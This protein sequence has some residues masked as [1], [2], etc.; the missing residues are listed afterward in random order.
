M[1]NLTV[2]GVD[3][4][5][6]DSDTELRKVAEPDLMTINKAIPHVDD[7]KVVVQAGGACG[8]WPYFLSALFCEVYTFEPCPHNFDYLKQNIRGIK[9]I[10]ANNAALGD[11]KECVEIERNEK[12]V[13][14]Q[15]V[16]RT[17]GNETTSIDDL[18]LPQLDLL[19]LDIEGYEVKALEGATKTIEKFSPIISVET[20]GL[21]V[22]LGFK[23]DAAVHW[24]IEHGYEEFDGHRRD[25]LFR[26]G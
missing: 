20:N 10:K 3:F 4:Y 6:P 12:N 13:G 1:A 23:E 26:R 9:N 14:A 25:R 8:V 22:K 24:L 11:G 18:S 19:L 2:S 15:C 16:R 21:D 5:W 7:K 17:G